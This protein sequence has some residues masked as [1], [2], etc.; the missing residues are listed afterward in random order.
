M[1]QQQAPAAAPN[2]RSQQQPPAAGPSSRPQQAAPAG[3]PSS[4]RGLPSMVP[5]MARAWGLSPGAAARLRPAA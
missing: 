2:S 1:L 5:P 4:E 3:S